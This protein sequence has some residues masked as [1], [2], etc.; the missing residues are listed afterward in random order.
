MKHKTFNLYSGDHLLACKEPAYKIYL[1]LLRLK[2]IDYPPNATTR[3][4]S[5]LIRTGVR[6]YQKN[7]DYA[8]ATIKFFATMSGYTLEEV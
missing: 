7:D 5:D 3:L 1:E 2:Y 6:S 4:T 8:Y